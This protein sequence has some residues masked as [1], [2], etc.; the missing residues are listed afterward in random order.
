MNLG[1]GDLIEADKFYCINPEL[2][3]RF[4]GISLRH[5]DFSEYV[6]TKYFR[7]NSVIK[8][9][10][11]EGK[12]ELF[13]IEVLLGN[14]EKANE[15]GKDY[16]SVYLKKE[17]M[18]CFILGHVDIKEKTS[19]YVSNNKDRIECRFGS[20]F[21]QHVGIRPFYATAISHTGVTITNF[22]GQK[23]RF[24]SRLSAELFSIEE[25]MPVPVK[26]EIVR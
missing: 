10:N 21:I 13:R 22:F 15:Y 25:S 2:L 20:E 9:K 23:K 19:Y 11:S 5:K 18:T 1:Y 16:V 24:Y 14:A 26:I 4:S 12:N 3:T 6:G 17:E 7:V 8:S